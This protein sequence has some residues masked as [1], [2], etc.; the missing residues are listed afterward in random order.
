MLNEVAKLTSSI[1]FNIDEFLTLPHVP[2]QP[3]ESQ[4]RCSRPRTNEMLDGDSSLRRSLNPVT[5]AA[6]YYSEV[7]YK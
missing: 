3:N 7:K 5:F 6:L 4:Q 1:S 2:L